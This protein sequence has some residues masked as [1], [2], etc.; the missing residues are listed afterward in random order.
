MYDRIANDIS[1]PWIGMELGEEI[2]FGTFGTV[3]EVELDGEKYALK[4]I[5]IPQDDNEAANL[6]RTMGDKSKVQDYY[7]GVLEDFLGE[8]RTMQTLKDNPHI[9]S[10]RDYRIREHDMGYELFILMEL[11][12]SFEDYALEHTIGEKE[13]IDIGLD[14]CEALEE[15]ERKHIVHRDLKP[16]N[17]LF[18]QEG[19]C[20]IG[21]FG[22]A[23]NMEK[24]VASLSIKGTFT[25]MS[26]EVYHAKSYD[27]RADIYSVGL[28]LHRLTNRGRDPFVDVEK[29]IVHFKDREEALNKRMNGEPIPAPADASEEFTQIIQKATAYYPEKRYATA[30]AMKADLKRLKEG[31]FKKK[32]TSI[33][34]YGKRTKGF[35]IRAAAAIAIIIG[36]AFFSYRYYQTNIVNL[37][38]ED[39]K[40]E[41]IQIFKEQGEEITLTSRLN[42]DGVLYI[43]SNDDVKS[44]DDYSFENTIE[45]YP[46]T[47]HQDEIKEIVFGKK[48]TDINVAFECKNLRRIVINSSE[49]AFG[50]GVF[51]NCKDL[52]IVSV[53]DNTK[54][55]CDSFLS[56][57]HPFAE[58]KIIE[59]NSDKYV[60]V[61]NVLLRYNGNQEVV[62][63]IPENISVIGPECFSRNNDIKRIVLPDAVEAIGYRAFSDCDSL[64][65][66]TVPASLDIYK[67]E[68]SAFD[69]TNLKSTDDRFVIW[70]DILLGYEGSKLVVVIPEGVKRITSH[71][72]S[73]NYYTLNAINIKEIILPDSLHSLSD[74]TFYGCDALS[75][76]SVPANLD[77]DTVNLND[78]DKTRMYWH[79]MGQEG[80]FMYGSK[81]LKFTERGKPITSF[82]N[83]KNKISHIGDSV[84]NNNPDVKSLRIPD[85]VEDIGE[86]AFSGCINLESVYIPK[87]VKSIGWRAFSDC[88]KLEKVEFEDPAVLTNNGFGEIDDGGY[89]I[90]LADIFENTPWL[91]EYNK[92]YGITDE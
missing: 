19:R 22:V 36:A 80:Y 42:G 30:A 3:Y 14:L 78:F 87:S 52:A 43:D 24:T 17:I 4:H 77:Y 46:W 26:P 72:F 38:D 82:P 49:I 2:G 53:S 8:I 31:K 88:P 15:C 1:L 7:Q 50:S 33:V 40:R 91:E 65:E 84:F 70:A 60:A 55:N 5:K 12:T 47:A 75:Y 35:Y 51:S 59:E 83:L 11:L 86:D 62:D 66:V 58:C 34:R 64:E 92:K 68:E 71:T 56:Y 18:D 63:D 44:L 10:I 41:I 37:C 85:T 29:Q 81:L 69:D 89:E 57:D 16:D 48:V 21:D 25:Y 76:V 61:G 54:I 74:R 45:P 28:I 79:S 39:V 90:F 6:L 67:V 32:K 23:K 20:K 13:A 27:R 73:D 9:V